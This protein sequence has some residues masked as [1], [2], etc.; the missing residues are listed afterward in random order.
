MGAQRQDRRDNRRHSTTFFVW[1]I[2]GDHNVRISPFAY[3]GTALLLAVMPGPG[4]LYI[5]GRTLAAGQRDGIASCV[6]TAVGGSL[7]VLAGAIGVSALLM[8]SARARAFLVL[9][10]FGGAYLIY[11]G[12]HAWRS[13]GHRPAFE[14][15]PDR[16]TVESVPAG[17]CCRSYKP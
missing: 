14:V 11:L 10:V 8:A 16:R 3:V 7:H 2:P 4:L 6:G 12:I 5:A 13:S 17:H 1:A 15:S 9:K